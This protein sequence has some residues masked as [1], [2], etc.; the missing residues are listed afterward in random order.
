M[1]ID[2]PKGVGK[3]ETARRRAD[4]AWHLDDEAQRAVVQADPT[5]ESAPDGTLLLDEWQHY[6]PIWDSVRRRVDEGALTGRFLLTGSASP[7]PGSGTHSGAGRITSVRMRPMALHERGVETPTVSLSEMLRGEAEK[8]T[9]ESVL[10][11]SDYYTAI[12]QSGFPGIYALPPRGARRRLETYLRRIV[13][14]EMPD[15]GYAVRRPETLRRW[16][17]AY[18]AASSQTTSYSNIL[19]ST[20]SGDGHQP[21]KAPP[22][23]IAISSRSCGSWILCLSLEPGSEQPL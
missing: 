10:G 19:D 14:R 11:A 9:G 7:A 18:A 22:S 1:A 5:F 15:Q 6:S 4:H 3:T 21:A 17:T 16:L 20:T 8:V 2:G 13:D 23:P 12:T